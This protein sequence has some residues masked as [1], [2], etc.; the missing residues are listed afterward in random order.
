MILLGHRFC[1]RILRLNVLLL[2]FRRI[3]PGRSP[4]ASYSAVGEYP[5]GCRRIAIRQ[6][7]SVA[8]SMRDCGDM[9]SPSMAKRKRRNA[10]RLRFGNAIHQKGCLGNIVGTRIVGGL[11][12]K[13]SATERKM[14]MMMMKQLCSPSPLA[15]IDGV[16]AFS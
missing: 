10:E 9:N 15:D 11:S 13:Y 16:M 12:F 6:T 4:A 5:D 14:M 8:C 3:I 2:Y 1:A 7:C